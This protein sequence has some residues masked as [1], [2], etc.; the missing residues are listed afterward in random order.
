MALVQ[1]VKDGKLVDTSASASSSSTASSKASADST[2]GLD[3]EAFLQL[4]VAQMRYQDPL[5]PTDNTEYIAQLATFSQL[6]ATQNL[7]DTVSKD[8]SNNLVGKYVILNVTDKTGNVTTVNGKVDYVMYENGEVFLAVND[9]LYSLEDL[10]TVADANY[11]EAFEMA[12]MFSTMIAK[13][14]TAA[15]VTTADAKAVENARAVY[16]AMN[17]YQKGFVSATDLLKLTALEEKLK[18][19]TAGS[20][21]NSGSASDSTSSDSSTSDSTTET[22]DS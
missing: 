15:N 17:S 4:L 22:T 12:N 1:A 14:P 16:D 11:Y 21:S 10:D 5:Q 18:T 19:L 2:S 3:K 20:G 13:L 8:M 6:E 7:E 9:G